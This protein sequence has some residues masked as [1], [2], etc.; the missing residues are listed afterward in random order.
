M[1]IPKPDSGGAKATTK[2]QNGGSRR[3]QTINDDEVF[4]V[5]QQHDA[6]CITCNVETD[7]T[8]KAMQC[9][10]CLLYDCMKCINMTQEQYNAKTNS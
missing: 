4:Q 1:V 8:S 3:K 5:A 6:C 7:D 2:K 10:I 9:N